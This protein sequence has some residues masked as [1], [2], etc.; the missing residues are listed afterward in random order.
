[1]VNVFEAI[2]QIVAVSFIVF[3]KNST[4]SQNDSR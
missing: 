3:E 4:G 1:M 2:F